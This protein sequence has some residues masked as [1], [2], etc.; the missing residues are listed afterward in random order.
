LIFGNWQPIG[1]ALG[2]LLFSYGLSLQET[3][4]SKPIKALY[5]FI[6]GAFL[7][8]CLFM[9]FGRRSKRAALGLAISA[10]G[11]FT[12]YVNTEKVASQIVYVTPY[13]I[14]LIVITFASKHS[15]PPAA[16]GVPWRRGQST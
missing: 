4:G 5:L 7:A 8:L 16:V 1:V 12:F 11:L 10:A 15:R 2:A 13:V 3:I 9:V 14:V 6:A